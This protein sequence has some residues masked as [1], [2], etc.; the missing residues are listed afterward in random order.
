MNLLVVG[1]GKGSWTMRGQQ[2]GAALGARVTSAPTSSDWTWADVAVLVKK[3]ARGYFATARR[4]GVAIVWDALDF[5][6]QPADNH[7]GEQAS[8]ALLRAWCEELQPALVVGATRRMAEAAG[9]L[10]LPHHSWAGLVPQ[11]A[12]ERVEVVAYEG[13]PQYLGRWHGELEEACAQRGWRFVVNPPDLREVDIFVGF[14]DGVWDGYMCREWKSGVK[15]VNAIAAG[16]PF[17]GQSSAALSEI[18]PPSTVVE[19]PRV[20]LAAAFDEW[21]PYSARAAAVDVCR[22]LAPS[23]TLHAIAANYHATLRQ[24][25]ATCAA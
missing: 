4:A 8:L 13:N 16:R 3:A 1:T 11:P 20:Q 23:Y 6:Q 2:L 25:E 24:V 17:I 9:G 7:L 14:R 10:Y 18:A 19:S 21:E 5:W 22:Q 12:R 15:I